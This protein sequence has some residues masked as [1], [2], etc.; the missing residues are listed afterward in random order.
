MH[1]PTNGE[2]VLPVATD[3]IHA[4]IQNEQ[5]PDRRNNLSNLEWFDFIIM[6]GRLQALPTLMFCRMPSIDCHIYL[7]TSDLGLAVLDPGLK[8]FVLVQFDKVEREMISAGP[9]QQDFNINVREQ[10]GVDFAALLLAPELAS[11]PGRVTHVRVWS[12]D[13]SAVAWIN[14]LASRDGFS[15]NLNRAIGLCEAVHSFRR[16]ATHLPG[17]ANVIA[18]ARIPCID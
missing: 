14:K 2:V 17:A 10:L 6:Y 12:D 4:K 5:D 18:D 8:S 9:S 13:T 15:Q 16:S 1:L 7:D 11:Q 3:G